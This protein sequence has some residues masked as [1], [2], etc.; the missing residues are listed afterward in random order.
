[1]ANDLRGRPWILDTASTTVPVQSTGQTAGGQNLSQQPGLG[2]IEVHSC[3]TTGFVFRNYTNG[4][5]SQAIIRDGLRNIEVA[6]LNGQA[7]G[8]PVSVGEAW[9]C[10]QRIRNLLLYAID[11][12]QVEVIIK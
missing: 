10:P 2:T 12:G 8:T 4:T 6:V 7:G 5:S 3:E 11:S 1:M 9:F